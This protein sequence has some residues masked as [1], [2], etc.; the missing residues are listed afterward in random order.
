[1]PFDQGHKTQLGICA[2]ATASGLSAEG[3]LIFP[4]I[5]HSHR[6]AV[7]ADQAPGP[8]PSPLRAFH[9]NRLQ[10]LVM[11]RLHGTR[12]QSRACLGNPRL[13]GYFHRRSRHLQPAQSLQQTTQH[14]AIR[15]LHVER[16]RDHVIY[17]HVRRQIPLP[18][19]GLAGF[20]KNFVHLVQRKS[21]TDHAQADIIGDPGTLGQFRK[22][23]CH[24]RSLLPCRVRKKEP[25]FRLNEQYWL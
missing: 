16:Q 5:G 6:G 14:L 11:K 9:R 7:Q 2:F 13:A 19:A 10:H 20:A 8:V 25:I 3:G 22:C 23:S 15:D 1:M 17:H 24:R 12:A 18:L 4:R 21:L